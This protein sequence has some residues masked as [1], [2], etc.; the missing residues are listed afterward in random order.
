MEKVIMKNRFV[1]FAL[2]V[3]L[4]SIAYTV[5]AATYTSQT[6]HNGS[7]CVLQGSQGAAANSCLSLSGNGAMNTC[8]YPIT[9][10]CP[11]PL[12]WATAHDVVNLS[13]YNSDSSN[14]VKSRVIW[15]DN[16]SWYWGTCATTSVPSSGATYLLSHICGPD[17][18]WA[19]YYALEV[20]L[21]T[22]NSRVYG[23]MP[24]AD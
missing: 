3:T 9:V 2:M 13:V 14:P 17:T 19:D 18:Y 15:H 12:D 7:N 11:L 5:S 10:V 16:A 8:S 1:L 23:Y 6:R 20:V 24:L 22:Y 21:P 4:A